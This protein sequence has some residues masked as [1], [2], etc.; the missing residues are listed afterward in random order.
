MSTNPTQRHTARPPRS[1][2]IL[3][4]VIGA[5]DRACAYGDRHIVA[6]TATFSTLATVALA[7]MVV[8]DDDRVAVAVVAVAT[9]AF[10]AFLTFVSTEDATT[11]LR[12]R[13]WRASA[14]RLIT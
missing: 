13:E 3:A 14:R 8:F 9:T 4:R 11:R 1:R 6:L 10:V 7:L 12:H 2:V 5:L